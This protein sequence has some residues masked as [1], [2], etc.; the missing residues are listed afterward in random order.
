MSGSVLFSTKSYAWGLQSICRLHRVAF[1][2]DAVLQQIPPPYTLLSFQQAAQA[3]GLKSAA[4]SAT[5]VELC[6]LPLPCLAVLNPSEHGKPSDRMSEA[7]GESAGKPPHRVVILVC[8]EP[9]RV[10]YQSEGES[11]LKTVPLCEFEREYAGTVLLFAPQAESPTDD[12]AMPRHSAVFGFRWFVPELLRHRRIWRDVLL[13]S[14]AIQ[15][16]AL[17]AP[18]FTQV[19]IDKVIVHHTLNTLLVIGIALLIFTAFTAVMSW[20]RQYLLL[21]TGNRIDAV[22]GGQVFEHLC[23]LPLRY[24][25]QRSSG[26]LVA[27]VQGTEAIREFLSGAAVT[28]ILDVPF[29]LLFLAV[30]FYYSWVLTVVAIAVLLL[31]VLISLAITPILRGRINRQFLLG[32][33]NQA[34]LTEYVAGMATV[35]SLQMEPRLNARYGEYLASYLQSGFSTRQL[36]NTY[37]V[38]ANGLEQLLALSILCFG[39]WLVM[40]TNAMTI[41][42]L[43]AFQMF[44]SRLSGPVLRMAGLWQQFQEA[45]I[46][47]RRLG[48]IM[49]APAEP[50]SV[51]ATRLGDGCGR[52][53]IRDLSFRHAGNLPYLYQS[54]NLTVESGQCIALT[55]PSGS[56]KSTL[57]KLL[58][59]FYQP[60][61]GAVL[62]GNHDI[63]HLS[64]NELRRQFGVV[65]QETTLF[66]GTLYD[67]LILAN[68][69][70][71]FEQ[72]VQACRLADIHETIEQFPDGYQTR[73]GEHGAGLSG[74]QKQRIAI[75]RAL[76]KRPRILIFD[77]ATNGLD[78]R[79]AAKF[80]E[81]VNRLKGK[82]TILF[83]AH[84]LPAELQ[85]DGV[86]A[87]GVALN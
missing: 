65:P 2:Q 11:G 62:V 66:S 46:A 85:V 73:V 41:G 28:L 21:H 79:T 25:E 47:V 20:M 34:F 63:R 55:G 32:A 74:G 23:R 19:I 43:V 15:L 64:A 16:L 1:S 77:E 49:N 6:K 42:M 76:L 36:A 50:Y 22:L 27:R 8:Y 48:D 17:A 67:N 40:T 86:I 58:Q 54:L 37:N 26:T 35:K 5:L 51:A 82:V 81:T 39:A 70:A 52:I 53:E 7:N 30:M 14:L 24:F 13:A 38:A 60:D 18:V 72:V 4:R 10:Q 59:G 78:T 31:I 68:S 33:R 71:S 80:A 69:H 29:L 12:E 75:A 56:G 61:N 87:L 44:A 45:D 9:E 84:Q 83:I 57:A 3:M